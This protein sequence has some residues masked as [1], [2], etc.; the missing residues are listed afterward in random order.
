MFLL[1]RRLDD[2]QCWLSDGGCQL[3]DKMRSVTSYHSLTL[4][5]TLLLLLLLPCL[6]KELARHRAQG[7]VTRVSYSDHGE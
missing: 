3:P 4:L 6:A 1:L 5:L 2:L 7:A